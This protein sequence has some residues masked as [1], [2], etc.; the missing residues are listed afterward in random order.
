MF[1]RA[2]SEQLWDE[3]GVALWVLVINKWPKTECHAMSRRAT[4]MSFL[5]LFLKVRTRPC[6]CWPTRQLTAAQRKPENY[7]EVLSGLADE[8]ARRQ[9]KLAD[10]RLR[11]RRAT[12][13]LTLYALASWVAYTGLWY[14]GVL[15]RVLGARNDALERATRTIPV[16][17]GPLLYGAVFRRSKQH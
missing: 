9:T 4:A 6:S 5:R 15:P 16:G 13:A 8:I 7:E 1:I 10:I 11:E 14:L 2:A 12:L 3:P 17:L